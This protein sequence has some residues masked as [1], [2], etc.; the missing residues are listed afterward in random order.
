MIKFI[1]W[2][3]F[4]KFACLVVTY[5]RLEKLKKALLSYDRELLP[6]DTVIIVDNGSQKEV[7]KFLQDWLEIR[8]TRYEVVIC[9]LEK[10]VG[11]TY[12]FKTGLIKA[13]EMKIDW[14]L[15]CDDDAYLGEDFIKRCK[16]HISASKDS[17][18]AICS[19][20]VSNDNS[21]QFFHRRIIKKQLFRI[22][23]KNATENDYL[24]PCFCT[25]ANATA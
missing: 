3:E 25:T 15:I 20:V 10:N 16:T 1:E 4:M 9:T 7:K 8:K 11:A 23:E 14:C 18:G 13:Q 24:S 12:G 21:I 6:C 2:S 5:N 22:L 19:K 17:V